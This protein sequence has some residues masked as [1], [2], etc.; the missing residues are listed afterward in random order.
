MNRR[1]K[2]LFSA[3]I[4]AM[5]L[6]K[7][8]PGINLSDQMLARI[9]RSKFNRVKWKGTVNEAALKLVR[10]AAISRKLEMGSLDL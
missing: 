5:I 4:A 2:N 7:V 3:L 1:G 8:L 6:G 10:M 9:F